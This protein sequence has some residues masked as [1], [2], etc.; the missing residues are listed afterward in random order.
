M[1]TE[2]IG[3][4][5]VM[6]IAVILIMVFPVRWMMH[7]DTD[8]LDAQIYLPAKY[9][10]ID[11][12]PDL[13]YIRT[14]TPLK[15]AEE[16]EDIR[17]LEDVWVCVQKSD[18]RLTVQYLAIGEDKTLRGEKRRFVYNRSYDSDKTYALGDFEVSNID[19][20]AATGQ[21]HVDF[22]YGCSGFEIMFGVIIFLAGVFTARLVHDILD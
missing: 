1:R 3:A 8:S 14:E 19:F 18:Y 5:I 16:L 7:D 11:K 12:L 13:T 10:R 21:I 22:V 17:G 2:E 15:T 6:V 9:H 20:N 4:F